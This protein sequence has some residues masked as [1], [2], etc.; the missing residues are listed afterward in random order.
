M[1]NKKP[2]IKEGTHVFGTR[3]D[4]SGNFKN[5]FF[6]IVSGVEDQKVGVNGVIVNPV[7][8]KN[9]ISQGKAGPRSIEILENPTPDNCVLALVYRAEHEN[10]TDVIN[11]NEEQI[12]II[13]PK[14]YAVLD[15][16]IRESIPEIINNVLSLSAGNERDQA[17]RIL[18]QRMDTLT[19]KNLKRTLYSVSRSLKILN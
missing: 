10:F 4:A 17:K 7:G 16:W 8:L 6:G 3:Q 15:G 5:I 2:T 12:L 14:V 18:R 19:D 9:K 1:F 11:L 13:P